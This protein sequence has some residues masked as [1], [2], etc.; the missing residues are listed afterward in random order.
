MKKPPKTNHHWQVLGAYLFENGIF[1]FFC[2][3]ITKIYLLKHK[4]LC[5]QIVGKS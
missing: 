5:R 1:H 3:T 2:T 4:I